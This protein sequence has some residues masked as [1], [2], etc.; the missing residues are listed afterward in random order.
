MG[1]SAL[2]ELVT[3]YADEGV[4]VDPLPFVRCGEMQKVQNSSTFTRSAAL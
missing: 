1:Q 4:C 3:Q 2:S